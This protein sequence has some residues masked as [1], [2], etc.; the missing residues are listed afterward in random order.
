MT[1]GERVI[2]FIE[3][4]CV[5]PEGTHVGAKVKLADFQ[6]SFIKDIYDNPAGTD[7]AILS[8]ARKNAKTATIAFL[9]LAHLVGPEA[10]RNSHIISGAMSLDQAAQVYNYA[11]KTAQMSEDLRDFVRPIPSKKTLI[12]IPMNVEYRAISAEGKTAHG[13]SPIVAIIDEVGQVRGPRSDF[14][15]SITTAQGAYQNPLLIYMSTQAARDADLFSILIDDAIQNKPPK[16]VCHIYAAD[17]DCDLDD[18]SQWQKANPGMGIFRSVDDIRKQIAEAKRMPSKES[19]VRNLI[20]NQRTAAVSPFVSKSVWE[21]CGAEPSEMSGLVLRCGLDLSEKTDLTSAVF[22]ALIN[23]VVHV[24][25]FFWVPEEGVDER[26]KRDRQPYD[27]WVKQGYIR[28]T[29]GATVGYNH[30]VSDLID[31]IGDNEVESIAFDR[32]KIAAFKREC[33]IQGVELPLVEH[34]QGYKG[35]SE[36]INKLEEYM[37][38]HK[39]AH[40]MNPVLTMCASNAKVT[41]DEAGGRKFDKI[42]SLGR[43]DGFVALTMA[44]GSIDSVNE[45]ATSSPWDDP[46]FKM[47]G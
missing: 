39:M 3:A 22:T 37:L 31:I 28:T 7:T 16:T 33:E 18:E 17:P 42:K 41:R 13:K 6:K 26:S 38:N 40:G 32:W 5:I 29:P 23:G 4:F 34:G 24:W 45:G 20:L 46:K 44:V 43:I 15:D 10:V 30:V 9:V 27:L 21:A 12:G 2:A 8:I 11:A 19:M 47:T 14:I 1:R 25:P 36:P 35:M